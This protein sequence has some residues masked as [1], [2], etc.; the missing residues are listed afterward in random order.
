MNTKSVLVNNLTMLPNVASPEQNRAPF[1]TMPP[2]ILPA[3]ALGSAVKKCLTL[4]PSGHEGQNQ[5]QQPEAADPNQVMTLP[6]IAGFNSFYIILN[7]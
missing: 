3:K 6:P 7:Q 5:K 2:E 1:L 4:P